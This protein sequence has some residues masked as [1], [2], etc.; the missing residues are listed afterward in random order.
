MFWC[1]LYRG[2]HCW[3]DYLFQSG[4]TWPWE[5]R[6]RCLQV[7]YYSRS[8]VPLHMLVGSRINLGHSQLIP[9]SYFRRYHHGNKWAECLVLLSHGMT[10]EVDRWAVTLMKSK[11]RR[12]VLVWQWEG[13]STYTYHHTMPIWVVDAQTWACTLIIN[14]HFCHLPQLTSAN[15]GNSPGK[16]GGWSIA[17][18]GSLETCPNRKVWPLRFGSEAIHGDWRIANKSL[19]ALATKQL[20]Q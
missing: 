19:I 6:N 1:L 5:W 16:S 12:V 4:D 18:M 14:F 10:A 7:R 20:K 17:C 11:A 2:V 3:Q 9:T 15:S 13:L 8:C